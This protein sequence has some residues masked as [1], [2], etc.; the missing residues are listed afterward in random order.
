MVESEV[1]V[2]AKTKRQ[3]I[4]YI[5]LLIDKDRIHLSNMRKNTRKIKRMDAASEIVQYLN[6]L[7]VQM[8]SHIS[9]QYQ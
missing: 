5:N 4:D 8:E 3:V 2:L 7:P 6:E 9:Y 1:A